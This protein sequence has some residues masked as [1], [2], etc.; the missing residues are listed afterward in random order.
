VSYSLPRRGPFRR[1]LQVFAVAGVLSLATLAVLAAIVLPFQYGLHNAD[2]AT[3][4]STVAVVATY[5]VAVVAGA[6]A[7]VAYR[8]AT[9]QPDLTPNVRFR[10]DAEVNA[11]EFKVSRVHDTREFP[12]RVDSFMQV[13]GT[14]SVSNY[15]AYSARNPGV[16]VDFIRCGGISEIKGWSASEFV[17]QV[18]PTRFQWDGGTNEIIHGRWSR[19]LPGF[20]FDGLMIFD[21]DPVLLVT[22][23]ADGVLPKSWPLHIAWNLR[24]D[25]DETAART[26]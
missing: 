17:G 15:S 20:Y 24:F 21:H 18:G 4:V 26:G 2:R 9:G 22:V 19:N 23:T 12:L 11:P 3:V 10:F 6:V 16:R 1:R 8:A 5:L 13:S 25:D 14:I 7:W